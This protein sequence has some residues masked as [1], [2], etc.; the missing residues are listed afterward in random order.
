MLGTPTYLAKDCQIIESIPKFAIWS[1]D[2]TRYHD[3]LIEMLKEMLKESFSYP[4]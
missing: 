3:M 4:C 1:R 2:P